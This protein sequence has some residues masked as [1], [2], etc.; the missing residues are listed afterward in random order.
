MAD[1]Y[2]KERG[3]PKPVMYG[4]L[5]LLEKGLLGHFES[6]L[7]RWRYVK[8][9]GVVPQTCVS[10]YTNIGKKKLTSCPLPLGKDIGDVLCLL[11]EPTNGLSINEKEALTQGLVE[12]SDNQV[13]AATHDATFLGL[14]TAHPNW[15]VYDLE[16]KDL[17]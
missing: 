3:I 16:T 17:L 15:N 14:A 9:E 11:D 2:A 12:Y 4:T 1:A 6:N 7:A 13:I 5:H 8:P 10:S